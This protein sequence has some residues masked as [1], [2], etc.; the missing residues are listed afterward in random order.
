MAPGLGHGR[1]LDHH[2]DDGLGPGR[3]QQDPARSPE[4]PFDRCHR[5]PHRGRLVEGRLD[6]V[7]DDNFVELALAD[8]L[9]RLLAERILAVLLQRLAQIL[10]DLLE[11]A[12]AGTIAEKTI[13]IFDF[14]IESVH[15]H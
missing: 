5:V 1:C 6:V 2:A 13:A 14:D 3:S 15:I 10:H 4:G 9:H 7:A 11:R 12:L 8:L